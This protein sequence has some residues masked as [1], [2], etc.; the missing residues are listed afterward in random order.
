MPERIE[1]NK[2]VVRRLVERIINQWHIEELE[3]VFTQSGV[4]DARKDFTAFREAFPDWHMELEELVAE[5][6]TVVARF[7]CHGTHRG[8][9][10]GDG[11]T[12]KRM[13][14]DEVFFFRFEGGLI[15]DVWVLEDTWKRKR[16]LGIL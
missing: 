15:N 10:Q 14:V 12:D 9:W 11:P 5:G 3:D 1:Q 2:E 4:E 7:K 16:Q 6:D 13:S 8:R